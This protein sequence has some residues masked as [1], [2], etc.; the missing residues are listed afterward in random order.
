MDDRVKWLIDQGIADPDR[1]CIYGASYVG[2]A[3]LAD[4][5]F[6]PDQYAYRIDYAGISNIFTRM[7]GLPPFIPSE[8]WYERSDTPRKM[9]S[10]CERYPHSFKSIRSRFPC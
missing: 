2:Y 1:I 7:A 3:A 6:T 9:Q 8:W 4:V 5:T 10:C